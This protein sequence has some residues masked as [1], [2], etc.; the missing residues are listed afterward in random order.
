[1]ESQQAYEK[2]TTLEVPQKPAFNWRYVYITLIVAVSLFTLGVILYS[3]N[4]FELAGSWASQLSDDFY[5]F[6]I[7][8]FIA[9]MI[10]GALGMAY[11][12]S[13]STFLLSF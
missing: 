1:M 5:L 11:G 12:V 7:A 6:M 3:Y 13:A 9:Q 2:V 8:G 4:V 10:D